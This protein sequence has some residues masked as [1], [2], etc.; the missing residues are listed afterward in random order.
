MILVDT[1][2]WIDHLHRRDAALVE[3][4]ERAEVCTHPMIIGELALGSLS[5]RAM[6]LGLLN[7]LVPAPQGSY[8]EVMAFVESERLFG[9]GLSFVDAHLLAAAKLSASTWIWTRDKR[10]EAVARAMNLA[11]IKE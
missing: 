1:S 2:V 4:L 3:H 8:N 7:N 10:L 11:W 9:R 6:V 5:N